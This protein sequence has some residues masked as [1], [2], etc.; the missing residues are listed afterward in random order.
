MENN[1]ICCIE[2]FYSN[3]EIRIYKD[4]SPTLRSERIGLKI[5]IEQEDEKQEQDN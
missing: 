1:F 4:Y 2:D 5:C 3:R